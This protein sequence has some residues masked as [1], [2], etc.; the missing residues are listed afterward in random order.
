M[1]EGKHRFARFYP[2]VLGKVTTAGITMPGKGT[3]DPAGIP[4]V[5]LANLGNLYGANILTNYL[6]ARPQPEKPTDPV[7]TPAAESFGVLRHIE[8]VDQLFQ[9]TRDGIEQ[10]RAEIDTDG[11]ATKRGLRQRLATHIL[12]L[13]RAAGDDAQQ[14]AELDRFFGSFVRRQGGSLEFT[15]R[16]RPS[17]LPSPASANPNDAK[18]GRLYQA[19][20]EN[21][22]VMR[23]DIRDVQALRNALAG[24]RRFRQRQLAEAQAEL[25]RLE[26]EIEKTEARL[27]GLAR[28]RR[29]HLD[30][31]HVA[32]QLLYENWTEVEGRYAARHRALA[33]H[34]GLY[35]VRAHDVTPG[36]PLPDPLP[37]R[38][39][40]AGEMP[41]ACVTI[42]GELPEGLQ[43]FFETVLEIP[44]RHWARLHDAYPRLPGRS[45]LHALL[46]RHYQRLDW[47]VR[48]QTAQ[49]PVAA[50]AALFSLK[51]ADRLVRHDLASRRA[52]RHDSLRTFQ[53]QCG[54]LLSLVDLLGGPPHRLQQRVQRLHEALA[55]AAFCLLALLERLPP[56]LRLSWAEAAAADRLPV[57]QPQRW[58]GL[59]QAGEA[60][61][62]TLRGLLET[63][64]W[65]FDQL[66]PDADGTSRSA[67]RNLIRAALLSATGDDPQQLLHGRVLVPPATLRPGAALRLSLNREAPV[68]ARLQ[69]RDERARLIGLLQ[70]EDSDPEGTLATLIEVNDP[71][72]PLD[73]RLRVTG[74]LGDVP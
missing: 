62:Q 39:G 60:H 17:S 40:T 28:Q 6:Q 36:Q 34:R 45:R 51:E 63:V 68:G 67:L 19:L 52:T 8:P 3:A 24:Y 41:P 50:Q 23:G 5:E 31:L 72:A 26:R 44:L 42:G 30:D 16:A 55:R 65:W 32:Q 73:T 20:F 10:L 11:E 14:Q 64:R 22:R 47:A 59:S 38:T 46:E 7:Y 49:A 37:M 18:D 4:P 69:L 27:D 1:T 2:N 70:V 71:D 56:G 54:E 25:A 53:R 9:I 33:R 15:W 58:P 12:G 61:F 57:E 29:D 74:R 43:P 66:H 35:Y 48:R 13:Y 21:G